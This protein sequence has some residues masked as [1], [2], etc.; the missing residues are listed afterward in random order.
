MRWLDLTL[1]TAAENLALDEALLL[2]AEAGQGGEILRLWE[3]PALAVVLGSGCQFAEE[4][5]EDA[6][7]ADGVPILRRSSGG[8]TV[9]LGPG[10]LCYSLVLRFARSPALAEI[11]PSYHAILAQVAEA[12]GVPG[13]EQ[14]GISD[15]AASGRKFSGNAQQRKRHHLLHHG[16]ILYKFDLTRISR[17]LRPPPRQPDYRAGRE[18]ESFVRNLEVPRFQ[19][20]DGLRQAWR[21]REEQA[22]WPAAEVRRLVEEKYATQAWSRRR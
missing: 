5:N 6:C 22:D 3:W 4:T 18:H 17:Y 20:A 16:T 7:R 9:L 1:P 10:C 21:A 11:R 19:L 15:L 12:L 14:A 8:G 13:V 2:Q